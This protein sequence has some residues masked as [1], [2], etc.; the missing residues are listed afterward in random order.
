MDSPKNY[1]KKLDTVW[2][3]SF[4]MLFEQWKFDRELD[5]EDWVNKVEKEDPK[6]FEDVEDVE[7][8]DISTEE[9]ITKIKDSI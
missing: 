7:A 6:Y 8:E 1:E 3:E 5:Y 2:T 4:R 9:H